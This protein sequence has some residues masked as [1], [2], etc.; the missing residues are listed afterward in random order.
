MEQIAGFCVAQKP[1]QFKQ[2]GEFDRIMG[3]SF[4][5]KELLIMV[6]DLY[7]ED[8]PSGS[9]NCE[10]NEEHDES[11]CRF[12]PIYISEI[13]GRETERKDY[14]DIESIREEL[15]AYPKTKE[16]LKR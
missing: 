13:N 16:S 2:P 7:K 15:R 10:S 6:I 12:F 11:S 8:H 1:T 9:C 5:I 4:S 3:I 14:Q